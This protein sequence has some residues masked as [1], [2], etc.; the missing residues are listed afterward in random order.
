MYEGIIAAAV[1][2][3]GIVGGYVGGKRTNASAAMTIAAETVEM[4][5]AQVQVVTEE[6]AERDAVIDDL[7]SRVTVLEAMV[8]QRA[9][10]NEVRLVVDRIAVKV[11]A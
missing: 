1:G 8:T 10:V 9:E 5:Q 11:G 4:L 2:V 6:K 7:R 3:A